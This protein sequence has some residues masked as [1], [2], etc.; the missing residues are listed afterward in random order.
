MQPVSRRKFLTIAGSA[1]VAA[2]SAFYG[3]TL[4]ARTQRKKIGV[5]LVGLGYYSRDLLAPALQLTRYCELRGIVTGSP[6]KIPIW[7]KR[8]GIADG[9][10]YD[11][12]NLHRIAD[13]PQ[14]DVLYIVLPTSMHKKYS[15]IAADA[16]KHVWCE[17]PM[18]M[19]VAECREMVDACR[20]NK[21][22]LTVGYR[23]QH[24]PN[25]RTVIGY[26]KSKPYG[27]IKTVTAEAGYAGGTPDPNDWRI[28]RAM[29]GGAAY[30]MGVYPLNA[31]RY[32]T[33]E[34]P[35]AVTARH[36]TLRPEHF[37][38]AD[39]STY[40]TLEFPSGATASCAASVGKNMNHLRTVC[41]KGWYELKPF[42]AYTDVRGITSDGVL[43]NKTIANQQAK[44]MDDDALAIMGKSRILVPGE[45]GMRDIRVVQAILESAANG[46]KRIE[47]PPL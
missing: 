32:V 25:T 19:T 3:S 4:L 21:V 24:E 2:A 13:N 16:G 7:Q 42:Q 39:E 23:L 17:K 40:F 41:A 8:Y 44:Q 43:L 9:N 36:E 1:S 14:I 35:V 6:E 22:Q 47:I 15:M 5:A 27:A 30:D 34:E 29:G 12:E 18:A 20:R 45:E 38:K 46:S 28:D 33:G 37:T 26:A 10:V 11:Y 31:A